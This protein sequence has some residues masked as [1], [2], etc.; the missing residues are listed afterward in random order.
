[1]A[2]LG[3]FSIFWNVLVSFVL[4]YMG[5]V[6]VLTLTKLSG[7]FSVSIVSS[8]RKMLTVGLSCVV[9]TSFLSFF[10]SFFSFFLFFFFSFFLFFFFSFF[11]FFFFS[12]FLFFFFLFSFFLFFFLSS[13]FLSSSPFI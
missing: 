6:V 5:V 4:H 2:I 11:L 12:F 13:F 1:M 8:C 7:T 9:C 10:L 3:D